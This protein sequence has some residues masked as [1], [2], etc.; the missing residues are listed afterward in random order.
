MLSLLAGIAALVLANWASGALV[1]LAP[2]DVP[3]VT[4]TTIDGRVLAFTFGVS[5]MATL[6]FSLAPAFQASQIDLNEALKQAGA[7][8]VVGR[9]ASRTRRVLVVA[10]IAL[11]VVLLA[12]AGLL[13]KSFVALHNVALGF[14]PEHVL[15]MD[16]SVPTS[17]TGGERQ[18]AQF[19]RR[20][21]SLTL[22]YFRACRRPVQRW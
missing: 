10:E 12:G 3:R 2:A 13:I 16:S 15:V 19:F 17:G 21:L 20:L 5:M 4:E 6:L 14:R 11:S 7:R 8:A 22:S 9:G 18:A 1:A